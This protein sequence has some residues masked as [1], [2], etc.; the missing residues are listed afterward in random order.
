ML[1]GLS[2]TN[3]V[4]IDH[5]TLSFEAGMTAL[6][7]ETGA[8]KS[9]L[10]DAL[11]L[12]LGMRGDAAL[13]RRGADQAVVVAEFLPSSAHPVF[14][15]LCEHS[16]PQS[17]PL[18]LRRVISTN[19]RTRCFINDALVSVGLLKRVGDTLLEIHGQFDRLLDVSS[20]TDM[21][22]D[23]ANA[24]VE[25]DAV[26]TQ[27]HA[28]RKA[29]QDL[30]SAQERLE[31]LRREEDYIRFQL[32]ELD[33]LAIEEGEEERLL[34]KREGLSQIGK[35]ADSVAQAWKSLGGAQILDALQG[36]QR[37]LK[38]VGDDQQK[39]LQA[40][41]SLSAA[42]SETTEAVVL[43]EEVQSTFDDAPEQLTMIDDRLHALRG[44][45]RKYGVTTAE[46]PAFYAQRQADLNSLDATEDLFH[47]LNQTVSK[48]QEAYLNAAQRLSAKRQFAAENLTQ[49]VCA[50]LPALKLPQAQFLVR[51]TPQP[52][53]TWCSHGIDHVDFQ[54]AMN[55]GQTFCS[56][57]KAASGGELAR[58]MLA[59]KSILATQSV[60]GTL[61][62]DEI[63]IGV[64]GAVASAI[65]HRLTALATNLQVLAI[66][67]SPQVAARAQH[68]LYVS[69]QEKEGQ[70]CTHVG[71]LIMR[72]RE[73]EIARM[74]SGE[75]ITDAARA[76]AQSLLLPASKRN[77]A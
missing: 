46:L 37:A 70:M 28:W 34:A 54:V 4:L 52:E 10:L 12:A 61:I 47:T 27:Y 14:E 1:T 31:L 22:D 42:I 64:G 2:I 38:K 62:F 77:V 35:V 50:E 6:T 63:D 66:T 57:T 36:A 5:L 58:L 33:K 68:H 48:T 23:F 7:G 45:A 41:T 13:I 55:K 72:D 30:V 44:A 71:P 16:L 59:L 29:Q 76:A 3:L 32:A 75:H 40:L 39:L 43:L 17:M 67:H 21:L 18:V 65:G 53:S 8:G 15:M 69:K 26:K 20:H 9:I 24:H 11:S 49:A 56:L 73:D 19:G 74:L 25:K 51:V 60:V